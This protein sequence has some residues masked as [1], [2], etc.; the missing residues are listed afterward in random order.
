[1]AIDLREFWG[2]N[3]Y[4]HPPLTDAM[5]A[6]AEAI[7]GVRLPP[8]LLDLLRIQNG[9]YTKGFAHPMSQKTTW[10]ANHVPLDDLGGIVTAGAVAS[11]L[12]L[13]KSAEM[14]AEWDLPSG[15]T[16]S[17]RR[18]TLV[19]HAGLPPRSDT[20]CGVDRRRVP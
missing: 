14:K 13:L 7:L 19:G 3:C 5:V 4:K 6:E 8:L 12:N 20:S 9:G 15:Q 10:S 2:N 16:L 18:R 11:P 17:I 1:M